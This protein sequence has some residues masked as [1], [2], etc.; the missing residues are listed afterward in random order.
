MSDETFDSYNV[1]FVFDFATV[2][3]TV[4][5]LHPDAAP[6]LAIDLLHEDL[7]IPK[8]LLESAEEVQVELLDRSVL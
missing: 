1:T 2:T 6:G 3:T 7:L 4:F 5:A 8:T